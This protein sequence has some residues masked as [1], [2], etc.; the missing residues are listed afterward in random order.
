MCFFLKLE[1]SGVEEPRFG[2]ERHRPRVT[3]RLPPSCSAILHPR[4]AERLLDP[5]SHPSPGAG[6]RK[7]E[8]GPSWKSHLRPHPLL[9]PRKAG[10]CHFSPWA[11]GHP[12]LCEGEALRQ[13]TAVP[14]GNRRQRARPA[15]CGCRAPWTASQGPRGWK[16]CSPGQAE[17]GGARQGTEGDLGV[18]T[19]PQGGK[20]PGSKLPCPGLRPV[21]PALEGGLEQGT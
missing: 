3:G 21:S 1:T 18:V 15:P 6:R 17:D 7:E 20:T 19:S 8:E 11:H 2:V 16:G 10:K 9:C 12:R 4:G 13:H 14:Q 5:A